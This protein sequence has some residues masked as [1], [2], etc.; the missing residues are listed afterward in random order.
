LLSK[1]CSTDTSDWRHVLC[2]RHW[3]DNVISGYLN[4]TTS[5]FFNF[6]YC[7]S[8]NIVAVSALHSCKVYM[9][10]IYLTWSCL[11][12]RLVE[13]LYCRLWCAFLGGSM[14]SCVILSAKKNTFRNSK[15]TSCSSGL[16]IY[17]FTPLDS[18]QSNSCWT[19][20]FGIINAY[21]INI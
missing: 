20:L 2:V 8:V 3:Y 15:K 14:D 21:S 10:N 12:D 18:Y 9:K 6:Y 16:G 7:V 4:S 5:T 11:L 17:I 19:A 13:K 1:L